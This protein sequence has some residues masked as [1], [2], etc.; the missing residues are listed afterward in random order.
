[1]FYWWSQHAKAQSALH[2]KGRVSSAYVLQAASCKETQTTPT[3]G[4]LC[5]PIRCATP[6]LLCSYL[7]YDDDVGVV[8]LHRLHQDVC[9][10]LTPGHH[11]A[12]RIADAGV[13]L[14]SISCAR[15]SQTEH[16]ICD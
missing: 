9:L 16:M 1:V 8:V 7:V 15:S 2:R 6:H 14:V 5:K 10:L 12:A 3:T 11:Q 4:Q 13:A